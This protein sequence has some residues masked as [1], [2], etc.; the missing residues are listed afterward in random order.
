MGVFLT[1]IAV[2][3][4]A[5]VLVT[6]GGYTYRRRLSPVG[7]E[8]D[9]EESGFVPGGTGV[10]AAM[11]VVAVLLA[12]V[13]LGFTTFG[14]KVST[15]PSNTAPNATPAQTNPGIV[16]VNPMASPQTSPVASP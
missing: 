3:L 10:A 8:T 6:V 14:W 7:T 12:I 1:L 5:A 13:I 4:L 11:I 16:P 2:I 9:V 15:Q